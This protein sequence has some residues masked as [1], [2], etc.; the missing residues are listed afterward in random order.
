MQLG[1]LEVGVLVATVLAL[2]ALGRSEELL[3]AC[4]GAFHSFVSA[5]RGDGAGPV[6]G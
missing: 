1:S 6:A 5:L 4:A 3:Q 2:Y